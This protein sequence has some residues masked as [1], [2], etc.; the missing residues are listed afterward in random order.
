[1]CSSNHC[2]VLSHCRKRAP[3][4]RHVNSTVCSRESVAAGMCL[5]QY[6]HRHIWIIYSPLPNCKW[7]VDTKFGFCLQFT[8]DFAKCTLKSSSAEENRFHFEGVLT[9]LAV[10]E[11]AIRERR[12]SVLLR[13]RGS[14]LYV[15]SHATG[16]IPQHAT[17]SQ[18]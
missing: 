13:Q 14:Q 2:T 4:A 5:R 10:S 9:S 11:V 1:M 17:N 6:L 8:R 12:L 3:Y 7:S 16:L 18:N 15:L